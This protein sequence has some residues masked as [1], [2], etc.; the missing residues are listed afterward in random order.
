MKLEW[1][2]RASLVTTW[3]KPHKLARHLNYKSRVLRKKLKNQPRNHH[4]PYLHRMGWAAQSTLSAY[5]ILKTPTR[6]YT[7]ISQPANMMQN[8]LPQIS[9][10]LHTATRQ[11]QFHTITRC[12]CPINR[13]ACAAARSHTHSANGTQPA[14]YYGQ[15]SHA[16]TPQQSR[17]N[18]NST[19]CYATWG[20]TNFRA[21]HRHTK[22]A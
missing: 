6:W 13:V 3:E 2:F 18:E 7:P 5:I 19:P 14:M 22:Q 15:D 9:L 11:P 16:N 4:E 17:D 8:D 10:N 21:S 12:I 20:L 1:N